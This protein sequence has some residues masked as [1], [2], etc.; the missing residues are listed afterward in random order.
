[1]CRPTTGRPGGVQRDP[2]R[3]VAQR[4]QRRRRGPRL[5]LPR[6]TR[7]CAAVTRGSGCRRST[8]ASRAAPAPSVTSASSRSRRT[9]ATPRSTTPATPTATASTPRSAAALL[10]G[11]LADLDVTCR[12][13]VGESQSAYALTTY[14][15]GVQPLTRALRRLP[16]PLPWWRDDAARRAGRA[17][18]LADFRGHEPV[19]VP[20]RPRRTGGHGADRDRPDRAAAVPPGPAARLGRGSG[21]GR[22][23]APRTRTSSRSASSRTSSAARGRSTPA[24]RRTS[25]APRCGTSTPGRAAAPA[26]PRAARLTVADG[27]FVV[28]DVGNA[29]GGI[30]TPVVDA[31][32]AILRGDTEPDAPVI[33]QLFGST[34][35][36]D[37]DVLRWLYADRAAP[38]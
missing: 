33:C 28:D 5:D 3:G 36:L 38:T 2:R 24:S 11:P 16:R 34:L 21:S 31:P 32:T 8:S 18:D 15:N 25:S 4:Q 9:R 30:R 27:A 22:S 1:M 26:A 12:L 20:R 14:A 29:R 19:V 7:S 6:P 10:D 37:A 17:L 13:A 23:P 35:P